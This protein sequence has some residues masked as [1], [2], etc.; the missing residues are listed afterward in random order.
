MK[1]HFGIVLDES[2][3]MGD[4]KQETITGFNEYLRAIQHEADPAADFTVSL[5][6]LGSAPDSAVREVYICQPVD[7]VEALSEAS[8]APHGNTPLYDAIG[9]LITRLQERVDPFKEDTAFRLL[10]VTDGYENASRE[11]LGGKLGSKIAELEHTG[12]WSFQFI[13]ARVDVKQMAADLQVRNTG[14]SYGY[15]G[16]QVG[17]QSMW[18]ATAQSAAN[19][20]AARTANLSASVALDF[21]SADSVALAVQDEEITTVRERLEEKRRRIRKPSPVKP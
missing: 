12:A 20:A 11:W 19:Y 18:E 5:V 7:R 2:G 13:G 14:S 3:S 6:K 8:Y 10:I 4:L 15:S 1:T 16:S 21:A 9:T 17:T